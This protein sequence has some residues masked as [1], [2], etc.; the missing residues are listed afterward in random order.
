MTEQEQKVNEYKAEIERLNNEYNKAFERLKSQQQ[1]ITI[2]KEENERLYNF[3]RKLEDELIE[4]GW[5]EYVNDKIITLSTAVEKAR[6]ETA[7]EILDMGNKIYEMSYYKDNAMSRLIELIKVE[8]GV[9]VEEC[10][11]K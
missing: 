3:K 10:G 8:Y 2:L 4:H 5:A 11:V 6:K 7:K 1:E 9:K